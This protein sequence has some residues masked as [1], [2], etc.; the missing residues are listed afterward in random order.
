[1][2][3]GS[4]SCSSMF[5]NRQAS[6]SSPAPLLRCKILDCIQPPTNGNLP[7]C[8]PSHAFKLAYAAS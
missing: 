1:M 6:L 5:Y 4:A 3:Q 8:T 2:Q 7:G